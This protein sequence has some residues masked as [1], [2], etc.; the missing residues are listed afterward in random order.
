MPPD[1]DGAIFS[2]EWKGALW[3][4][5][6]WQRS[7][8]GDGFITGAGVVLKALKPPAKVPCGA[9]RFLSAARFSGDREGFG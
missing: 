8:G 4:S 5:F 1:V 2:R 3:A 6:A 7:D 9:C